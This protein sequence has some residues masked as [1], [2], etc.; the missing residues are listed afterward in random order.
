MFK[1]PTVP[2]TWNFRELIPLI[3]PGLRIMFRSWS[4]VA[5][6]PCPAALPSVG[7]ASKREGFSCTSTCTTIHELSTALDARVV[8]QSMPLQR[9]AR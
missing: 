4:G 8:P 7:H 5:G 2:F 3:T 1:P 6:G 9:E